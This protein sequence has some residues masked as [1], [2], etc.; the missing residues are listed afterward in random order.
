MKLTE[1]ALSDKKTVTG[2]AGRSTPLTE[3]AERR[4]DRSAVGV[5]VREALVGAALDR[6]VAEIAGEQA[7]E[8]VVDAAVALGIGGHAG[9][10]G[11]RGR[12]GLGVLQRL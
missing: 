12:Q 3:S 1:V 9:Q 5:G 11:G 2:A 4:G 6:G 10:P 8:F 7:P